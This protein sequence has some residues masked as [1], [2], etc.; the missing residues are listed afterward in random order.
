MI[1]LL[2]GCQPAP[3][4]VGF[5]WRWLPIH[6]QAPFSKASANL[7]ILIPHQPWAASTERKSFC[8]SACIHHFKNGISSGL[9]VFW[10]LSQ[11]LP[12][13]GKRMWHHGSVQSQPNNNHS[14]TALPVH[15]WN[16]CP[17]HFTLYT[18]AKTKIFK[19]VNAAGI[20]LFL[21]HALSIRQFKHMHQP[22]VLSWVLP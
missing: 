2:Q 15:I 16:T 3:G 5:P 9:R 19:A 7:K 11:S 12:G 14:P 6:I 21:S 17:K 10:L 18:K 1:D 20:T 8:C 13:P 4:I 22:Q